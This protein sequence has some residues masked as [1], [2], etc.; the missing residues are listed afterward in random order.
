MVHDMTDEPLMS[1]V[2]TRVG[3]VSI[4]SWSSAKASGTR[5]ASGASTG[6]AGRSSS[7]GIA[8]ALSGTYGG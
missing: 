6:P 2:T 8:Q 1:A 4:A 3:V 5:P 7:F